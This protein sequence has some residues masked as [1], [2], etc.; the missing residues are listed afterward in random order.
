M[1][2][3]TGP[4]RHEGSGRWRTPVGATA[5]AVAVLAGTAAI[6]FLLE[7]AGLP[8]PLLIAV[9]LGGVVAV[10]AWAG[11]RAP[12]VPAALP[13]LS[14]GLGI[15]A[16]ALSPA[17]MLGAFVAVL[18]NGQDGH[19]YLL[20][21]SAG[22]ALA[23]VW[24][25]A[26]MQRSGAR[27]VTGLLEARF[28]NRPLSCAAT[29]VA[30]LV[31]LLVAAADLVAVGVLLSRAAGVPYALAVTTA[32][33]L[34]L[35]CA[36]RWGGGGLA[37][38]Q[39]LLVG[40]LV[41]ALLLPLLLVTWGRY[42]LPA[43]QFGVGPIVAEIPSL[44]QNLIRRGLADA[45]SLRPLLTPF[46]A[47]DAVNWTGIALALMLG[48]AAFPQTLAR[49]ASVS[50]ASAARRSFVW[51]LLAL[52]GAA[53]AIP[54]LAVV[55][56]SELV[57]LIG[58]GTRIEAL[59]AWIWSLGEAGAL[60][61]CGAAAIDA[62]TVAAACKKI[63][64]HPALLRL[65]DVSLEPEMVLPLV[66]RMAGYAFTPTTLLAA[67]LFA[68]LLAAL[69][70]A[71][72][73]AGALVAETRHVPGSSAGGNA[74]LPV[75]AVLAAL[76]AMAAPTDMLT[77]LVW[78]ATI[79]ASALLPP[80]L[81]GIWWK[82]T[83]ATGAIAGLATGLALSVAYIVGTRWLA[84]PLHDLLVTWSDVSPSALRR[85][86]DL[87]RV[88]QGAAAGP[89]K[90]AAWIALDAQAQRMA[91]V[92]GLRSTAIVLLA[93]PAAVFVTVAVSLVTPRPGADAYARVEALRRSSRRAPV[94]SGENVGAA[95]R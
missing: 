61:I 47:L 62:D 88:W 75:C 5:P 15:A 90:D 8:R 10:L 3:G 38:R 68:A 77:L 32:A 83:T 37:R 21:V 39:P 7:L 82:R 12:P 9:M 93:F 85:L 78:A 51:G 33:A 56:K 48:V 29:G 87:R 22:L 17:M 16:I 58:K 34:G 79:S 80:L 28:A 95:S 44:E 40:L 55:A 11:L 73:A 42:G 57:S 49:A 91:G 27:T 24:L 92:F 64:R 14:N 69:T 81:L 6:V 54:A 94:V 63:A 71:L 70:A 53:T 30:L 26:P 46:V 59:P 86:E 76:V 31:M 43:V 36:W 13:P 89:A 60:R 72:L 35:V 74:V 19:V 50:D 65:Q 41:V 4:D 1:G 66:P 52:A 45:R 18:G 20:G 67:G 25:A 23:A 84:L 2:P